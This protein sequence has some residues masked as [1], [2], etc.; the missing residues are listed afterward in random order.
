MPQS[1]EEWN[2]QNTDRVIARQTSQLETSKLLVTFIAAI[3]T[4]LVS[5]ALL[6]GEHANSTD[7]WACLMLGAN[8]LLTIGAIGV[9]R[10][11]T[12]NPSSAMS[13]W[14]NGT[15]TE[16]DT[17]KYLREMTEQTVG[18]NKDIVRF[19]WE[20]AILQGVSALGAG[21]LAVFSLLEITG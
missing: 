7:R 4:T 21:L 13:Q 8:I 12:A 10:S 17:L 15:W 2:D 14:A 11:V 3:T 18:Y 9:D 1:V 5:T 20:I 16:A 6:L 19:V